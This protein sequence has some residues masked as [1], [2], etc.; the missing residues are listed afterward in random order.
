MLSQSRKG[1]YLCNIIGA[2]FVVGELK[3]AER[4]LLSH[5]VS[6][7]VGRVGVHVRPVPCE[8]TFNTSSTKR[9][10]VYSDASD[11]FPPPLPFID[12]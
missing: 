7:C 12:C 5:P 8:N 9:Y 2:A 10:Y 1:Y 3:F 6:S 4:H 11:I